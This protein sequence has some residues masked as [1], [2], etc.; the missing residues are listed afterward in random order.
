MMVQKLVPGVA[1]LVDNAV[2]G[3]EHAV[4][5]PVVACDLQGHPADHLSLPLPSE[6]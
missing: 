3:R 4:R 5:E 6:L 2:V 1:A